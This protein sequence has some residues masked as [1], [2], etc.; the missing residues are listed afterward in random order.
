MII[1]LDGQN[2]HVNCEDFWHK[3]RRNE[4]RVPV[5]TQVRSN[6]VLCQK[7]RKAVKVLPVKEY[8]IT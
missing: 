2:V 8:N 7:D 1:F 3:T 5:G 4:C 6:E